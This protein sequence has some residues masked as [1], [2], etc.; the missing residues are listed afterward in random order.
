MLWVIILVM[1]WSLLLIGVVTFLSTLLGGFVLLKFRHSLPYFFAFS[2]GSLMGVAFFDML[3]ESLELANSVQLPI[4]MLMLV[5]VAAFFLY[6]ILERFFLTHHH[7]DEHGSE[8]HGHILGPIGAGSL[9]VHS[10][11]DGI[12]I[13]AAFHLS[14]SMGLIVA[15]AVIFHDFTD[16]INTVTLMLKNKQKVG[17][18]IGFLVMDA[19]APVVGIL[20]TFTVHISSVVLSLILAFFVGEFIYI[21]AANLLPETRHHPMGKILLSMFMGIVLIFLLTLFIA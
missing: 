16:G 14:S 19:I 2:A 7:D 5:I 13:G 1:N 15:L 12:A 6:I 17:K 11:L 20:V 18:T 21:G 9:V 8:E 4:R 3:P 10:F